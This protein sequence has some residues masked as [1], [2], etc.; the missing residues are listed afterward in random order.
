MIDMASIMSSVVSSA[1][2]L[3][4]SEAAT[5]SPTATQMINANADTLANRGPTSTGDSL[6]R[7]MVRR[8]DNGDP[9]LP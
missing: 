6:T 4:S 7:E 1:Q 8:M 5:P 2:T 3:V 9:E